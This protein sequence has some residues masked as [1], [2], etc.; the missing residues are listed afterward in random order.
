[1][2]SKLH[3]LAEKVNAL[4][5]R[6]RAIVLVGVLVAAFMLWD[7]LLWQPM[8]TV[9]QQLQT[10]MDESKSKVDLLTIQLGGITG[11]AAIDPN[12]DLKK[13]LERTKQTLLQVQKKVEAATADLIAPQEMAQLL[14]SLLQQQSGLRLVGLQTLGPVPL[15]MPADDSSPNVSSAT[16]MRNNVATKEDGINLYQHSFILEFEGGYFSVLRYLQLLESLDSNFY[17]DAVQYEVKEYPSARIRL[18]LHTLSLS[19]G[20]IGV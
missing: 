5:L 3:A 6:E 14:E 12:A 18:H 2:N 20:W 16:A 8:N 10:Q 7:N 15:L 13:Q 9:Q 17:W 1:V 4:T 11:R 19:E